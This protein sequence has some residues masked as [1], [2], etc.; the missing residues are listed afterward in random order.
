MILQLMLGGVAG[1]MVIGKLYMKRAG[2]FFR[3]FG[4]RKPRS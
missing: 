3:Q 1:A 4:R 2:D